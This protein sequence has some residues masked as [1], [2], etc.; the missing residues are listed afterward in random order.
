MLLDVVIGLVYRYLSLSYFQ[1]ELWGAT[2][3]L[4]LAHTFPRRIPLL[5]IN[6]IHLLLLCIILITRLSGITP[7]KVKLRRHCSPQVQGTQPE[8]TNKAQSNRP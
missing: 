3:H 7:S 2:E 1:K 4:D 6:F 5:V 8:E